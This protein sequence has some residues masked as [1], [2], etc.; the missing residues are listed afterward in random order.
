ML[1]FALPYSFRIRTSFD[2]SRR[3]DTCKLPMTGMSLCFVPHHLYGEEDKGLQR[4]G[5]A[6]N[7]K[8][9]IAGILRCWTRETEDVAK[10]RR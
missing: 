7:A 8:A 6:S 3:R 1:Y 9:Q 10:G 2:A 4:C 5:E